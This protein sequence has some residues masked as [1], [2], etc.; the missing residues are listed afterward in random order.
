MT[1]RRCR[2]QSAQALVEYAII[3]SLISL[4]AV[5]TLRGI[6]LSVVAKL[7]SVNTNLQ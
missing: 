5:T 7:Q 1:L 2:R 4:T 6:G 3:L